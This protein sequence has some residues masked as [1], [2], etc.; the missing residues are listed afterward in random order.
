MTHEDV[1]ELIDCHSQPLTVEDLEEKTKSASKEEEEEHPEE[2]HEEIEEPGLTL[3]RLAAMYEHVKALQELSQEH[4]DNMVCSVTF[5]NL[6]DAMIL[7]KTIFQQKKKQRQQLPITMFFSRKKQPIRKDRRRKRVPEY[8]GRWEVAVIAPTNPQVTNLH[9]D[10]VRRGRLVSVTRQRQCGKDELMEDSFLKKLSKITPRTTLRENLE[11]LD[12]QFTPE[13]LSLPLR[14]KSSKKQALESG[15][16][17]RINLDLSNRMIDSRNM[18][19]LESKILHTG[20]DMPPEVPLNLSTRSSRGGDQTFANISL[21]E[22]SSLNESIDLQA[23]TKFHNLRSKRKRA[24]IE[25]EKI[26]GNKINKFEEDSRGAKKTDLTYENV[27]FSDVSSLDGSIIV[28]QK[29]FHSGKRN[30]LILSTI[31]KTYGDVSTNI[32]D[33]S[34]DSITLSDTISDSLKNRRRGS[35]LSK[36]EIPLHPTKP[37]QGRP[38]S[39]T[40]Q[41]FA[42]HDYNDRDSLSTSSEKRKDGSVIE[43][44]LSSNLEDSNSSLESIHINRR[45]NFSHRAPAMQ[46]NVSS[47]LNSIKVKTIP[48]IMTEE[49]VAADAAV[50]IDI[51]SADLEMEE[52]SSPLPPPPNFRDG[53]SSLE[54]PPKPGM[55]QNVFRSNTT[56]D[57]VKESSLLFDVSPKEKGI[58][59]TRSHSTKESKLEI[60]SLNTEL[61]LENRTSI[62]YSPQR[63]DNSEQVNQEGGLELIQEVSSPNKLSMNNLRGNVEIFAGDVENIT[64]TLYDTLVDSNARDVDVPSEIYTPNKMTVDLSKSM[65]PHS[66]VK[67]SMDHSTVTP[68]KSVIAGITGNQERSPKS[69]KES[70]R[71]S[72]IYQARTPSQIVLNSSNNIIDMERT[73]SV[74]SMQREQITNTAVRTSPRNWNRTRTPF[75]QMKTHSPSQQKTK[76]IWSPHAKTVLTTSPGNLSRENFSIPKSRMTSPSERTPSPNK[77]KSI[78]FSPNKQKYSTL[79]PSKQRTKNA[80]KAVSEQEKTPSSSKKREKTSSPHNQ[81]KITP[82]FKRENTMTLSTRKQ[83]LNTPPRKQSIRQENEKVFV[84]EKRSSPRKQ[85]ETILSPYM[86]TETPASTENMSIEKNSYHQ[87]KLPLPSRQR[88]GIPS[89]DQKTTVNSSVSKRRLSTPT[90]SNQNLKKNPENVGSLHKKSPSPGKQRRRTWSPRKQTEMSLSPGNQSRVIAHLYKKGTPSHSKK[91]EV[92]L[93]PYKTRL[94]TTYTHEEIVSPPSPSKQ[95]SRMNAETPSKSNL[96]KRQSLP[97]RYLPIDTADLKIQRYFLSQS[98]ASGLKNIVL[99]SAEV[100]IHPEEAVKVQ[101]MKQKIQM[102]AKVDNT[103]S[104]FIDLQNN[105]ASLGQDIVTSSRPY[106]IQGSVVGDRNADESHPS[107][108]DERPAIPLS[109]DNLVYAESVNLS[110]QTYSELAEYDGK[111]SSS[112]DSELNLIPLTIRRTQTHESLVGDARKGSTID[113]N[114]TLQD[115]E[116]A[117]NQELA[118][119]SHGPQQS[120]LLP[121]TP[122]TKQMTMREFLKGLSTKPVDASVTPKLNPEIKALFSQASLVSKTAPKLNLKGVA[123]GQKREKEFPLTLP[124]A[125]TREIFTHYAKCKVSRNVVNYV[126]KASERFW[127]NTAIDLLH[128]S[129]GRKAEITRENVELLMMRQGVFKESLDLKRLVEEYLPA[130]LWDVLLPTAYANNRVYPPVLQ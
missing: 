68:S 16:K 130:E 122:K 63:L 48:E 74:N 97:T 37:S 41:K 27:D 87:G 38:K 72:S 53:H 66:S 70:V 123:K 120:Q 55:S 54:N 102:D 33:Y 118:E 2:T 90:P 78:T 71:A 65:S 39:K 44:S 3:E 49:D 59:T 81:Q 125:V 88:R 103:D 119:I 43:D 67:E 32:V 121:G 29:T 110:R 40:K 126:T 106:T 124:V 28:S 92:T 13:T 61:E 8:G 5:C 31:D 79:T 73:A 25:P 9:T 62:H 60:T 108:L 105:E 42:N 58:F 84:L 56:S 50:A 23:A 1:N 113:K 45:Q 86:K 82:S 129:Q 76:R 89:P 75:K 17:I 127:E 7:Y 77:K 15:P 93:S 30:N 18:G 64:S 14:R 47:L 94:M 26:T 20:L 85:K 91:K 104:S 83:Q 95:R 100:Q 4:D 52:E 34:S 99:S 12:P 35:A 22:D 36:L 109:K 101:R 11:V 24:H 128:I 51:N 116:V 21:G 19:T 57:H 114:E 6:D 107:G 111:E 80:E 46:L 96:Q 117:V 98:A 115:T 112:D 10:L 69:G